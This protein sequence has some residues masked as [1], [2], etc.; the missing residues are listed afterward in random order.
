[1]S[2][3]R[4]PATIA[5]VEEQRLAEAADRPVLNARRESGSSAAIVAEKPLPN[6]NV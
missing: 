5:V 3:I 4:V 6:E 1:M 2:G